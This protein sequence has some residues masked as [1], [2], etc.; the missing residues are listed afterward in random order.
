MA[1]FAP[2]SATKQKRRDE[3]KARIIARQEARRNASERRK[4]E[5]DEEADP[6]EN[7]DAFW[8]TF[9]GEKA[10]VLDALR[11]VAASS[12]AGTA[13]RA[14]VFSRMD[15]LVSKVQ[16]MQLRAADASMYLAPYDNRQAGTTVSRLLAAVA[17]ARNTLAPRR[18]FTFKSKR[19][20]KK[21]AAKQQQQQQQKENATGQLGGQEVPAAGATAAAGAAAAGATAAAGESTCARFAVFEKKFEGLRGEVVHVGPGEL[22]DGQ[23]FR[24]SNLEDCTVSLCAVTGAMHVS[25]LRRCRIFTGPV[26]GSVLVNGCT[27]CVFMLV[28]RQIR[29]HDSTKCDWYLRVRSR[30]I[31]EHCSGMRFAPYEL[32]YLQ[33]RQQME[34]TGFDAN[35]GTGRMWAQ[36]D[37]FRWHRA[38]HSP[39]WSVL[40]AEERLREITGCAGGITIPVPK[41]AGAAAGGG[42][43]SVGGGGGGGG[44]GGDGGDGG[45]DGDGGGHAN[46]E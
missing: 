24:L 29:I 8:D 31:I 42:G 30:P 41:K 6:T 46:T 44:G 23:E 37:D 16:A 18:K 17:D 26:A 13:T 43:D 5:L 38:Q 11:E 25:N 45:G 32:H 3:I 28:T 20:K 4:A 14:S 10:K 40:P 2:D 9:N 36:V 15:E 33:L 35:E 21:S 7:V 27:D 12:E 22:A 1:S 39:N 19:K 34:D